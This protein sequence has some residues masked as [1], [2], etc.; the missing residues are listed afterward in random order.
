MRRTILT[1]AALLV[2]GV[3]GA[4]VGAAKITSRDIKDGTI[5]SVDVRDGSLTLRDFKRS[6]RAKLRGATGLQGVPGAPGSVGRN[7][8]TD[9][10]YVDGP[11]VSVA[12]GDADV[13]Q[14]ACPAGRV[15]TGASEGDASTGQ[16]D[17]ENIFVGPSGAVVVGVNNS[18]AAEPLQARAACAKV[19]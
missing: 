15:A 8:V 5:K 4:A 14:A 12:P 11:V 3:P 13:A 19:S 10:T 6:E 1:L 7:G 9:I 18:A 17:I 2:I 16:L